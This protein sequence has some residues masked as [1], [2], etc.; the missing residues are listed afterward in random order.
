[1]HASPLADVLTMCFVSKSKATTAILIQTFIVKAA[2]RGTI[3]QS[4]RHS[5]PPRAPTHIAADLQL[6]Q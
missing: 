1:M 5:L 4:V 2:V 6:R 3:W